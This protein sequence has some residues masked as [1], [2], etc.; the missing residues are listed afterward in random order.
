MTIV[1][2]IVSVSVTAP[3][4][5]SG[6]AGACRWQPSHTEHTGP[7]GATSV[8]GVAPRPAGHPQKESLEVL[9][10]Q[11]SVGVS[12]R[13]RVGFPL[14]WGRG[15]CRSWLRTRLSVAVF[16]G[17]GVQGTEVATLGGPHWGR[18]SRRGWGRLLGAPGGRRQAPS[19]APGLARAGARWTP[20]MQ[21]PARCHEAPSSA[22]TLV[23]QGSLVTRPSPLQPGGREGALS[24][25]SG[26]LLRVESAHT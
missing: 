7:G 8:Q 4:S 25:G 20:V 22:S 9:R 18:S 11:P 5:P 26:Y 14:A 10:Q 23:T 6:G 12:V 19:G 15:G 3:V 13:P 16:R 21:T 17:T 24:P 2:N 1:L